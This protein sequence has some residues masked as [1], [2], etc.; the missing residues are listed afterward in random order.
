MMCPND[1]ICYEHVGKC[2]GNG[3][4][5]GMGLQEVVWV[6]IYIDSVIV[7]RWIAYIPAYLPCSWGWSLE[8]ELGDETAVGE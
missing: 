1:R 5:V 2:S 7:V 6:Y 8:I 4:H 3:K